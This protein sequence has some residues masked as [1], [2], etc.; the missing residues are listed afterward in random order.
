MD[1]PK[2]NK[3]QVSRLA[4]RASYD[5]ETIYAIL[6]EALY[7]NVAFIENGQPLQIPTGFVRID[8]HIYLHGSVGSHFLRSIAA[9]SQVCICATLMDALVLAR[10]AFHHSVNY[11][12]V[13][14]FSHAETVTD[15]NERYLALEKF[16]E[17]L[18]P[19]RW[20]TIRQ[21]NESEWRKTLVLKFEIK[22]ASAKIR[23]GDPIDDD[24]DLNLDIWA[25]LAHLS[26]GIQS[27]EPAA[28]LKPGVP[29]PDHL[30]KLN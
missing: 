23:K 27:I 10:S 17:K 1:F 26:S 6:D 29:L 25:G 3:N 22:E 9:G 7:C 19:G 18:I 28:D 20:A 12:S 11:R 24:E 14:V 2:T 5:S 8:N 4:K 30:R 15:E 13:V 21:P 16:T